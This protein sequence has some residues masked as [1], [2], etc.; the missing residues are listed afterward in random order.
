MGVILG[1]ITHVNLGTFKKGY[2]F[3][4]HYLNYVEQALK[5][6]HKSTSL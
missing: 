5:R 1:K 3:A 2:G 4:Q 6:L